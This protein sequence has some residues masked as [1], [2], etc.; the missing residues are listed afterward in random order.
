METLNFIV[1]VGSALLLGAGIGLERQWHQRLAGLRTNALVAVGASLFVTVSVLTPHENGATRVAGQVVSGIG[2]LGAGVIMHEGLNVTGLNTAATLWCSAAIGVLCG[3]GFLPEAA[4]GSVMILAANVL[5]RPLAQKINRQP[6]SVEEVETIYLLRV[7]SKGKHETRVRA[8]ILQLVH[9]KS[10]M[11]RSL[12]SV[13]TDDPTRTEIH[14]ELI[15]TGNA[16]NLMEQL[17]E[18]ISLEE[19]VS[20]ASWERHANTHVDS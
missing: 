9:D 20:S 16:D 15:C 12:H 5:L 18:S 3:A 2:F 14:A 7:V 6:I 17:V 4:I 13:G 19:G 1:R 11:L 8:Q 10:M